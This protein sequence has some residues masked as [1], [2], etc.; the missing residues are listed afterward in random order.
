MELQET[1]VAKEATDALKQSELQVYNQ[2]I[3]EM[4]VLEDKF[5]EEHERERRETAEAVRLA[6]GTN[7]QSLAS[8]IR[9]QN[10]RSKAEM[11]RQFNE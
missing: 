8:D 9:E 5:A 6:I 2:Y 7:N 1:L 4:K 10:E 11:T 3:T